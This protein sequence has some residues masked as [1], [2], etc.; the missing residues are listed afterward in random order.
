MSIAWD[1]QKRRWELVRKQDLSSNPSPHVEALGVRE[2]KWVPGTHLLQS[3]Q[4][5]A[6]RP[7]KDPGSKP[8]LGG[9]RGRQ[10]AFEG[11]HRHVP[12]HRHMQNTLVSHIDF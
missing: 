7:L 11:R 12:T 4:R 9:D 8:K 1:I 3:S 5:Q 10:V 2:G 6:S